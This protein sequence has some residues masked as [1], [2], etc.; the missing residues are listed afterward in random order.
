[1]THP[2]VVVWDKVWQS[3]QRELSVLCKEAGVWKPLTFTTCEGRKKGRK[4]L[5]Q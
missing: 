1:M 2:L 5:N 3:L 4:S